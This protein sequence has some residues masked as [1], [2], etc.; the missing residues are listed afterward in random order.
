MSP[1]EK[2][3]QHGYV[4]FWRGKRAEVLANTKY[5]AQQEAA[6]LLGARKAYEVAVELAE[7]DG[8]PVVHGP[9]ELP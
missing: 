2:Q 7:R 6:R 3:G 5:A 1:H 9:E 8:E 4:A